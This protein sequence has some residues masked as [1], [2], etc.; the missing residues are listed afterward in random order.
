MNK[1][2]QAAALA[3]KLVEIQDKAEGLFGAELIKHK[4]LIKQTDPLIWERWEEGLSTAEE[5]LL[6]LV[7]TLAQQHARPDLCTLLKA[8]GPERDSKESRNG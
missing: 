2:E 1:L 7:D 6:V 8:M 3:E 5:S 4:A